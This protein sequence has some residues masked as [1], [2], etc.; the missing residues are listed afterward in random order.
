MPSTRMRKNTTRPVWLAGLG[1]LT[2]GDC[3]GA[4]V[5]HAWPKSRVV[6]MIL[7]GKSLESELA[8]IFLDRTSIQAP[9]LSPMYS[10]SALP[11]TEIY[12]ERGGG[13]GW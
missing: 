13:E 2:V 12:D 9:R 11:F 10:E 4:A 7:I 3:V 5:A 6:L 8:Q 1:R